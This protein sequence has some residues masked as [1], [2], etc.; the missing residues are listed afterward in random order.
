MKSGILRCCPSSKPIAVIPNSCDNVEFAFDQEAATSFRASRPWIGDSPLLIYAGTFGRVNGLSYA[1]DLAQNLSLIGSNIR[2]LLVGDGAEWELIERLAH[3][4]NVLGKNL[5]LEQQISKRDIPA[6]F[7]AAT[8]SSSLFI[9]L[10]EMRVNSA[11]KFFD[12][13]AAGKPVFLNYGGWMHD[14]VLRYECGISAWGRR[15]DHVARELDCRLND[16]SWLTRTG[17]SARHLAEHYFDRDLLA[18]QLEEVLIS[19]SQDNQD[20]VESIAPGLF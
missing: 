4:S 17:R 8:I 19:V 6:L 15:L 20:R 9:D 5:F 14:F 12:S 1:V 16:S 7:S 11:N 2:L 18:S 13:L 10:P 3:D